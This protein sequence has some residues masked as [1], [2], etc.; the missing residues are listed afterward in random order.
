MKNHIEKDLLFKSFKGENKEELIDLFFQDYYSQF[1]T[2]IIQSENIIYYKIF[3]YLIELRFGKKSENNSLIYYSKS[4]LW[5]QI[6]KDEFIFLLRNFGILNEIFPDID[7]LEL[8]KQK[9]DLQEIDYIIS[10]HHP[11]HKKLIDKPFLLIL[12]SFFF[13]LIELIEKLNS[14]KVLEIINNLSEIVQNGEIYNSNLRLKSKDFYRYKTLFISIKLFNDK[15]VYDKEKIKEYINHIK[16]E[17]KMLIENKMDQ[18]S[19][20]IKNQIELL[21]NNLPDCEEKTKTI[22]KILISK[23]K[24]VT[25]I[26]CREILCDIV[27]NDDKLIKISN[28]F[29]IHILDSF[30]FTPDILES[31]DDSSNPFSKNA[32]NHKLLKKING[33]SIPK[34]L[35]ENLKYIF[36]SKICQYYNEELN[37]KKFKDEDEKIRGEIDIYLG[38]GSFNYFKSAHNTLIEINNTEEIEIPN[39]N[40]KEIFCIVYCCIFLENFVKYSIS[41]VTLVS[42]RKTEIINYLN[43]GDSKVKKS[44]KLFILKELKAKYI[45]E[46]TQFL[47]IEKWTEDYNLKDLFKDLKFEKTNSNEIQG[48]LSFLFY[49]GHNLEEFNNEKELRSI[50]ETQY[51]T[52]NE[53]IFLCNLDLFINE[54]LSTLKTEEGLNLCQNSTLMKCF[55]KYIKKDN[56][57]TNTTKKLINLFF[58]HQE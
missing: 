43:E 52:L 51:H 18:V 41:Q 54:N 20:E 24:E 29:F 34:I 6:Y 58:D 3:K 14:P 55:N 42:G 32:E 31:Q 33:K 38:E 21:L 19:E 7:F 37:N 57:F 39:K 30:N 15:N 35:K 2:S 1:I 50:V 9:I 10:P 8:V 46:R 44:F 22:M 23:Y 17:R 45:L 36:K 49:G 5:T 40:I 27:L 26:E 11:R 16:N 12:D 28:E 47:N 56:K 48:S 13:N 4:I 25:N 53:R